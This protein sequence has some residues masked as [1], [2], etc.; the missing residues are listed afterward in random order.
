MNVKITKIRPLLI[1]LV[2]VAYAWR[3][4]GLSNQSLWRDEVDA[5]YFALRNLRDTLGMFVRGA[6]NGVLYFLALRPWFFLVGAS[7]FA[8]RYPSVLAGTVSVPLLW[9]VA[10]H[11]F[12]V[13]SAE[14]SLRTSEFVP[15]LAATFFVLNPY[16]LWYGQEGKM[17]AVI[18]CLTLLATW[19]WLQ[20]IA[21]GGWRSWCAY[22]VTV[23]IAMYTHLLMVLLIPVHLLWFFLAW[24]QSRRYWL[25]YG[26]ALAGLTLP[27]LP[28]LWWQWGMLITTQ[29]KTG[30]SFTPLPEMLR[31]L[32]FSH[33]RGFWPSES[34]LPLTPLL[35][36]GLAG[37]VLGLGEMGETRGEGE[38]SA[39]RRFSLVLS[40]LLLPIVLIYALSLRQPIFTERYVIWIAPALMILLALGVQVVLSNAGFIA[41]PLATL[42]L[43]YVFGFW[44]YAGWQQKTLPMKYDLR[45]AVTY[46][47]E[48]RSPDTLLI[49]QIPYMQYS[50]RYYSSNFQ[51]DLLATSEARLGHWAGGLWT[52][53]GSSDEQARAAVDQQMQQIVAN[54]KELWVMRSEVEMWD[55]RHLMDEWLDHH[56]AVIDQA[57]FLGTQV[58]HYQLQ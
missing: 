22:L 54:T 57:E 25:G 46:I 38:L 30:F 43:I 12:L 1:L 41:K 31:L 11:L 47:A 24:P 16:Q 14:S 26:L 7:E 18:T 53:D 39:W 33:S 42:L 27:Y 55:Q 28:M 44:L 2:L 20:G 50:Y 6:D 36:L 35:F 52:N 58:K 34:L 17:Y 15:F 37:I 23:S 29:R 5:I 51:A 48:R 10:R 21:G 19:F 13:R 40:W 3:V 45:N 4:Q 32:L 56:G 8:L 49:L 9:Q